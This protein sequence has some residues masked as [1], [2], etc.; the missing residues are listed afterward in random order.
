MKKRLLITST[1]LMMVQ[2]LLPHIQ[3]LAENGYA[4]DI[5]CSDVGGRVEE[6]KGKTKAYTENIFV[7]DLQ[8]SPLSPQNAK[9]YKQLKQIFSEHRYDIVWTN[10]PVMGVAT[11]LAAKKA[12]KNGTTVLYMCHGFHFFNGAPKVNWLIY[13]PIEKLMAPRADCICTINTE[14]YKRAQGFKTKR[15]EYIHGIGINTDRLTPGENQNNIRVELGLSEDAFL[16]L[17]VGELNENKNQKVILKAVNKLND[18]SIHYILC[19]KG[20]QLENLQTLTR[21][22]GIE[23]N[24]HFLGYRTDVVDICSQAD[25]YVMPSKRE[26]LPVASLEAMYCGLPVIAS[27]TRGIQ[28]YVADGKSGFLCGT[29]SQSEFAAAILHM[30]NNAAL[31]MQCGDFNRETVKAYCL[32][33]VKEEVLNLFSRI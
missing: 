18:V 16:V 21:E 4:V 25:V 29:E 19:G 33:Q 23:N 20:D 2:F 13:Y 28:D 15:V 5:A 11:R 7:L 24:V 14:D 10:E 32:G 31:R 8:R 30:K 17:S 27:D 22:L 3:N 12:R 6:I 26:G 9:G 1:D